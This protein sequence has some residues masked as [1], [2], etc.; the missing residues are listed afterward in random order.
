MWKSPAVYADLLGFSDLRR[1]IAKLMKDTGC[2]VHP[3]E[4]IVTNGAL[5]A[6]TLALRTVAK[7]GDAIAIESPTYFGVLQVIEKLGMKA[8]EVTTQP[9]TGID[10]SALQKIILSRTV[11]AC[12]LMPNVSNPLGSTMPDDN[13]AS[14]VKM[15][16][17]A[18]IPLIEDDVFGTLSYSQPRPKA[19][20]A[21][22]TT[23]TVLYCSSFS[24][25]LAPGYRIGWI[26]AG[27]YQEQVKYQKFLDNISTTIIPQITLAEFLSRDAYK[28]CTKNTVRIYQ[29]RMNQLR[30]WVYQYFPANTRLTNPQ[31]GMVLWVELPTEID[32]LTLYR[33]ALEKNIAISPGILFSPRQEYKNYVRLSCGN[34]SGEKALK[35]VKKV[36]MLAKRQVKKG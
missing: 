14:V 7:T 35:A 11:K 22:D 12:V 32:S 26:V 29:Q 34:L 10:P 23:N 2:R 30:H 28:R 21:Y 36:G 18:Q 13:K 20:K 33:L 17:V 6:L 1:Q 24:K 31:G 4:I 8:I 3:N 5:E 27:K 16:A 9:N 25:T 19:A 15:L